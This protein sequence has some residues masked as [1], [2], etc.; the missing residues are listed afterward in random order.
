MHKFNASDHPKCSKCLYP[1]KL[2]EQVRIPEM[3]SMKKYSNAH[4]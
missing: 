3:Y 1:N 4:N 2:A